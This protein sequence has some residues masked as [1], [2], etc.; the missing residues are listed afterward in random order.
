MQNYICGQLAKYFGL[1]PS[2]ENLSISCLSYV[3]KY[4]N[5][6]STEHIHTYVD[7]T[8]KQPYD[9][10]IGCL[11]NILRVEHFLWNKKCFLSSK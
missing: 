6:C 8:I 4:D 3:F 1:P 5:Y 2:L 9:N 7:D 10:L 11:Y